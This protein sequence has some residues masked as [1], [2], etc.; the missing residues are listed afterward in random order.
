MA[1]SIQPAARLIGL[2]AT[3]G[4]GLLAG[5]AF[6]WP[7]LAEA[8]IY[9]RAEILSG[10][11]WRLWTGHLVHYSASHLT[12]DLAVFLAAGLWLERI[13]PRL[14]RGFYLLAPPAI[15]GALLWGE[16]ALERYAG[17]SGLAAGLLVLLALV[18]L[19]PGTRE[20][21]WFWLAVLALVAVKVGVE[22]TTQTPLLARFDAG[23]RVVPLA[24]LAGIACAVAAFL[25]SRIR[26]GLRAG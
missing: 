15:S 11:A 3:L 20:P 6:A 1:E 18:Q 19:Q 13:A 7:R 10:Q 4:I 14:A 5:A 9:G 23:V 12:W 24:H 21:R 16:P 26:P 8:F 25:V 2:R 17:L 22:T